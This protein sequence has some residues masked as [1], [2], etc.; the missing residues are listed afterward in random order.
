VAIDALFEH[1]TIDLSI[2]H[3]SIDGE[4][5]VSMIQEWF[6]GPPLKRPHR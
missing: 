4:I 6:D 1:R 5:D 2:D 3:R